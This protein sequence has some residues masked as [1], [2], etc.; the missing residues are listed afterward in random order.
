MVYRKLPADE[1]TAQATIKFANKM[2]L[3]AF[4]AGDADSP[5]LEVT[6]D[7]NAMP[8]VLA[9]IDR[10]DPSFNIVTP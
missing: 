2:R 7:V 9:A 1:S 8:S 3:L 4:A 10:P 6:G 5:G